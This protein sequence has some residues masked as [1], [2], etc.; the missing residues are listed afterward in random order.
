MQIKIENCLY[1]HCQPNASH[2]HSVDQ[3]TR[4]LGSIE[5]VR[6]IRYRNVNHVTLNRLNKIL[7]CLTLRIHHICVYFNA[8][9]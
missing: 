1:V 6:R 2:C 7:N 3:K 5:L 8:I 4:T 9:S